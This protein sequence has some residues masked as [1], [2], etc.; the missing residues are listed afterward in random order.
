[1]LDKLFLLS[2]S[3]SGSSYALSVDHL[4]DLLISHEQFG[5]NKVFHD[6]K[7]ATPHSSANGQSDEQ[8]F[9]IK[10]FFHREGMS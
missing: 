4:I 6:H 8:L 3:L 1:M 5:L 2:H 7:T 9:L 10:P